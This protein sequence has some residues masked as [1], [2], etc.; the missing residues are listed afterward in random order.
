MISS[1][2][3]LFG[4]F[5]LLS[6]ERKSSPRRNDPSAVTY[7]TYYNTAIQCE[8]EDSGLGAEFRMFSRQ[9]DVVHTHGTVAFL[10]S[11][12]YIP[13]GGRTALLEGVRLSPVPGN[14]KE[15]TYQKTIPDVPY[16]MAYGVGVVKS[17]S[18]S[19][20]SDCEK[21][22]TVETSDLI[23][24]ETASS[25]IRCVSIHSSSST[26]IPCWFSCVMPANSPRWARV[27]VPIVD[28]LVFFD[29]IC[30]RIGDDGILRIT[31]DHFLFNLNVPST[32]SLTTA[33]VPKKRERKF[34]AAALY[35]FVF[36]STTCLCH[37][38]IVSY[39]SSVAGSSA[40]GPSHS[41]DSPQSSTTAQSLS[42]LTP[43][44]GEDDSQHSTRSGKR[45]AL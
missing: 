6:G 10:K 14:P 24:D 41:Q 19:V 16:A 23:R 32:R 21:S 45:R 36:A 26:L 18:T 15:K 39:R 12:A 22:F 42:P 9:A 34:D 13:S 30:E 4:F 37:S 3:L 35:T 1:T 27:P 31:L 44:E 25:I 40:A 7:H 20:D 38:L 29:G 28:S 11:R 5:E 33:V 43:A 2:L 8:D 17:I